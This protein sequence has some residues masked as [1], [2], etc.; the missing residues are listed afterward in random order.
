MIRLH[1]RRNAENIRH[2]SCHWKSVY[3]FVYIIA[4]D[5]LG[6]HGFLFFVL[7]RIGGKKLPYEGRYSIS[8]ERRKGLSRTWRLGE[9][10]LNSPSVLFSV[11][12]R[13]A[14]SC[15]ADETCR[16]EQ[17]WISRMDSTIH[18][19][20]METFWVLLAL[21]LF[22]FFDSHAKWQ[23]STVFLLSCTQI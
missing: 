6:D 14:P 17:R 22:L 3:V 19:H 21:S 15:S 10:L 23:P 2:L 20:V 18:I 5:G 1:F 4:I 8:K 9:E 11:L 13:D 16:I 7:Q 12:R